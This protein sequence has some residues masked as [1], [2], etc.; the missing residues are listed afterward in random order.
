MRLAFDLDGTVADMQAALAREARQMFPDVD[1]STLPRSTPPTDD[2]AAVEIATPG[3]DAHLPLRTLTTAQRRQLWKDVCERENFWETLEEIEPGALARLYELVQQRKWEIV[4]LTSRPE[5]NG[6]TAQMQSH[7]WLK[8]KGFLSPS[9]LIVH[10]SRGKIAAALQIDVVVDDRVESCVD[11]A[12]DSQAR[13][14]LVWRTSE[15]EVPKN[16]R[17]LGIGA[18]A[19]VSECMD[20]LETIDERNGAEPNLVDRLKRLFGIPLRRQKAR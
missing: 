4:F 8:A 3:P 18:V 20:L 11:V 15:G 5:T 13:P 6:D 14:I 17:S 7:R 12:V 16:A 19:S 9:V 2:A 10:G 1:P